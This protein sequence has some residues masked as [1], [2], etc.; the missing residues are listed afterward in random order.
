VIKRVF[1]N[2]NQKIGKE[3]NSIFV[4]LKEDKKTKILN[5]LKSPPKKFTK[6]SNKV[7]KQTSTNK[8]LNLKTEGSFDST[9]S[10]L[11]MN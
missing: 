1:S 2:L 7:K 5:K 10:G 8:K 4:E 3:K 6:D 11:F 9:S